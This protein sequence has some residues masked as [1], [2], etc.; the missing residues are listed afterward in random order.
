[1]GR[2][3]E[4][5]GRGGTGGARRGLWGEW[6]HGARQAGM[7]R[8]RQ[9]CGENGTVEGRQGRKEKQTATEVEEGADVGDR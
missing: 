1:M 5:L 6:K 4:R 9:G 7:G 3:N 2:E 8:G